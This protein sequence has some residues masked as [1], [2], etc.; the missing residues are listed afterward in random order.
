MAKKDVKKYTV[1]L[2]KQENLL[3]EAVASATHVTPRQ[4]IKGALL[5]MLRAT[6]ETAKA[7]EQAKMEEAHNESE[8]TPEEVTTASGGEQPSDA[9]GEAT[10]TQDSDGG[11]AVSQGT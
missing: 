1:Y 5:E 6:I 11:S 2:G 3:L 9:E 4:Y 7:V 8:G 10:T